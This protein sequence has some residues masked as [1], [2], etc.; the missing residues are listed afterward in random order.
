MRD[1]LHPLPTVLTA[2]LLW[3]VTLAF[4]LSHLPI[5]HTYDGMVYASYV[6]SPTTT[7]YQLFHPH[8][9]LYNPLGRLFYQWGL[10]HGA[11]WDGILALQCLDVLVGAFGLVLVFH[12]M[13]RLTGDRLIALFTASGL[14]LTYSYW[15]FSTTPA[16][17][18]LASVTPLFVW[19]VSTGTSRRPL[20]NG[21]A[22]GLTRGIGG[23]CA[24]RAVLGVAEAAGIPA[25]GKAIHQFLKPPER[26]LGNAANQVAVSL[27]M[28]LVEA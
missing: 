24:C 8:H 13:V 1:K 14:S 21:I 27:G 12:L 4:Y 25:A 28:V 15:Y 20:W 3:L 22:T 19:W 16:V 10:S 7:A 23:L 11:S 9:L 17:R 6:E 18:I 5:N 26:A 2:V